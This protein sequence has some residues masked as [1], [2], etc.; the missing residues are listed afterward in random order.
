MSKYEEIKTGTMGECPKKLSRETMK[1]KKEL[2]IESIV[3]LFLENQLT[4][5]ESQFVLKRIYEEIAEC[6]MRKPV[7]ESK[8]SAIKLFSPR[9]D[10]ME[11]PTMLQV[12]DVK[13]VLGISGTAIYDLIH[14]K[15][16]GAVKVG[17]HFRIPPEALEE[18]IQAYT[19][20]K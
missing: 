2:I 20:K 16:L 10:A 3:D 8:R 11:Q 6:Q 19:N 15:K 4:F 7:R 14:T 1:E 17:S 18:Y 13:K 5:N 12:K 9:Y